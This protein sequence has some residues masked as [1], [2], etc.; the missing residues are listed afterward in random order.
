MN[1]STAR[2]SLPVPF[3]AT[4][5]AIGFGEHGNLH[6]F[7][8]GTLFWSLVRLFGHYERIA[9]VLNRPSHQRPH[10]ESD[11]ESYI[12]RLRIVLNDI[13][14]VIWQ[15]LPKSTRGLKAKRGHPRSSSLL[16][17]ESRTDG[18]PVRWPVTPAC[19]GSANWGSSTANSRHFLGPFDLDQREWIRPNTSP[20]WT[21]WLRYV[22]FG[23]I[24][25]RNFSQH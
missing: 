24:C 25:R 17:I 1:D 2:D 15:F 5:H 3:F 6:H 21:L 22:S 14:Y 23:A 7:E 9:E 18:T 8:T 12:V 13:A 4:L 10:L 16:V 19:E 11:I 20:K